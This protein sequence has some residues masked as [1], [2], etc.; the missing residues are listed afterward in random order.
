MTSRTWLAHGIHFNAE[1]IGA[2]WPRR[3][4]RQPLRS[5]EYGAGVR[6]LPDLRA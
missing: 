6:H 1:E 4:W 2:A 5:L 3:G